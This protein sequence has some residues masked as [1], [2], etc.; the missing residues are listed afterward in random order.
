MDGRVDSG[1]AE[2]TVE[3]VEAAAAVVA[4]LHQRVAD[5]D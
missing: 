1:Q 5:R 3:E 4:V 2:A